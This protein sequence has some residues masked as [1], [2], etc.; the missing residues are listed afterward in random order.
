M[1]WVSREAFAEVQKQYCLLREEVR[2]GRKHRW[3]AVDRLCLA[4]TAAATRNDDALP[5]ATLTAMYK[6]RHITGHA[7]RHLREALEALCR[8]YKVPVTP[9]EKYGYK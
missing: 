2:G 8:K 4:K 9:A 3:P 7:S 5:H 6:Q 1:N